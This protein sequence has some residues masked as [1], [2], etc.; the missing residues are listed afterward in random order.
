M[1]TN[2]WHFMKKRLSSRLAAYLELLPCEE[3]FALKAH[4]TVYRRF[5]RPGSV[6]FVCGFGASSAHRRGRKLYPRSILALSHPASGSI[7][8]QLLEMLQIIFFSM[9]CI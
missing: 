7:R 2:D 3:G 9:L 8:L 1:K 6:T 5:E 4:K